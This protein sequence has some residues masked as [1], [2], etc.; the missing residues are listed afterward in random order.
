[1]A[2]YRIVLEGTADA[3]D[4]VRST[5]NATVLDLRQSG[6]LTGTL[7]LDGIPYDA[8]EVSDDAETDD[9]ETDED[10]EGDDA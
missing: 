8:S 7:T 3:G 9:G 6:P 1:M 4:D 5:F 2:A 10:E